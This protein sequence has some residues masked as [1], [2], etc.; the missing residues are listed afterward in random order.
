MA[1]TTR[2]PII[3]FGMSVA[4]SSGFPF[5]SGIGMPTRASRS[6][7]EVSAR[8][9]ATREGHSTDTPMPCGASSAR[10]VSLYPTS[11]CFVAVYVGRGSVDVRHHYAHSFGLEAECNASPNAA[12]AANDH[13]NTACKSKG[14]LHSSLITRSH[15]TAKRRTCPGAFSA[16]RR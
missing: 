6:R 12:A 16:V 14:W 9:P 11:A 3:S 4:G 8:L 1:F 2:G 5:P 15:R 7:A 10:N 13:R